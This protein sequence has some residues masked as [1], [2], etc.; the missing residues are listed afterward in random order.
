MS[1]TINQQLPPP[2]VEQ[3]GAANAVSVPEEG[4]AGERA[5]MS[6]GETK[7]ENKKETS[8]QDNTDMAQ[9]LAVLRQQL[10]LAQ[11]NP[12]PQTNH[13][14]PHLQGPP[15]NFPAQGQG[16]AN[17]PYQQ[18]NQVWHNQQVQQWSGQPQYSGRQ[19]FPMTG[20]P[21]P[22]PAQLQ[23]QQPH[24]QRQQFQL[25][26]FQ[27]PPA[28]HTGLPPFSMPQATTVQTGAPQGQDFAHRQTTNPP[29]ANI[30]LGLLKKPA[31]ATMAVDLETDLRDM[32]AAG[33]G[34]FLA[35]D[36]VNEVTDTTVEL[37]KK[38]YEKHGGLIYL[39]HAVK[40]IA[41]HILSVSPGHLEGLKDG[42]DP[43]FID[44]MLVHASITTSIIKAHKQGKVDMKAGFPEPPRKRG[45]TEKSVERPHARSRTRSRSTS[46]SR[47]RD[48]GR[49]RE[50][51][52]DRDRNRQKRDPNRDR[53]SGKHNKPS[54][55]NKHGL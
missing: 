27:P 50:R 25:Q 17:M 38:Q 34:V 14:Q 48:R 6:A 29:F 33:L 2:H 13:F 44:R 7:E 26:N 37:L 54:R 16:N 46:R 18:G 43:A 10:A 35:T 47:S 3:D 22:S 21:Q 40:A 12:P 11:G 31:P 36:Q 52:R 19:D 41:K 24:V 1:Q 28:Q 5:E 45:D 9:Q 39:S 4:K 8:E 20:H 15:H 51:D 55:G 53:K 32:I 23:P 30:D 49:D 42:A